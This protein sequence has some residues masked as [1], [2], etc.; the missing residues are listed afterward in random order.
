MMELLETHHTRNAF[1]IMPVG[2]LARKLVM[3]HYRPQQQAFPQAA[4]DLPDEGQL[5]RP[6]AKPA[7]AIDPGHGGG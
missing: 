2:R 6:T 7:D 4:A 5:C 3:R 1:K